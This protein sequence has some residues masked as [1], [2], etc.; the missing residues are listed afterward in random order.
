M[1]IQRSTNTFPVGWRRAGLTKYLE[2]LVDYRGATPEKV[3]SGVFLVTAGNI[4]NGRIDYQVSQEFVREEEYEVIMRRGK[5]RIGD[6]LFTTE[7]PL[8]QVALVD[9]EDIALA[10]RIIKMRP[11]PDALVNRFLLYWIRS[12]PFQ[13]EL[14]GWAT[15]ST[16]QGIKAEKLHKLSVLLP[17]LTDQHSISDFLDRE[18]ARLDGLVAAKERVLELL[19]EKRR[20]LITRAVTCGITPGV[21]LQNCGISWLGEIVAHWKI[22]RLKFHLHGVEQGWSPQCDNIAAEVDEWGV[23]K[24]GCVNGTEF[25]PNENKRLPGNQEILTEF[26]V[27]AGD[28]LMS[29]ANTTELLGSTALIRAVRARLLLCDKLYRLDVNESTLC[30]EYLVWF[31]R[32]PSG[33]YE[34]ER[35]ATG[36]SNSMQN[37]GQDS[38]RNLW[39]PIPPIDEQRA[40]VSYIAAETSKLDALRSATERTISLLKERRAALIAAAVTGQLDTK[41]LAAAYSSQ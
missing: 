6:L 36:A 1:S 29:R 27:R 5:P 31:L 23:L 34:F 9:R 30:K 39:I 22:E 40:I 41:S 10:Q 21:P 35:D 33:R 14:V 8:G 2:S 16:A 11:K 17:P 7:A 13:A 25:D 19:A 4:R 28:V 24:A 20:A 3:P 18:T 12:M 38:V 32:C 26:E 37:I 15:G